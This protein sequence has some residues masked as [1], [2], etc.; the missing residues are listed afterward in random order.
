MSFLAQFSTCCL[1]V[2]EFDDYSLPNPDVYM[3]EAD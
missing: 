3:P 2:A 1:K